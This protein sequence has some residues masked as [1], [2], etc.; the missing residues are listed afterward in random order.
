MKERTAA[1][2]KSTGRNVNVVSPWYS[3][4]GGNTGGELPLTEL[5]WRGM[6][7]VE[8]TIA[9]DLVVGTCAGA[10]KKKIPLVRR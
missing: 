8:A 9:V 7:L 6:F 3:S 4:G 2:D 1:K 10:A 5:T